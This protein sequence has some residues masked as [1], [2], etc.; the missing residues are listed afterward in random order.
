MNANHPFNIGLGNEQIEF[1]V[2]TDAGCMGTNFRSAAREIFFL[3]EF[4][5]STIEALQYG[6][7]GGAKSL[8]LDN[9]GSIEVGKI[10]DIVFFDSDPLNDVTVLTQPRIVIAKGYQL[11]ERERNYESDLPKHS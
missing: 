9:V 11:A 5:A 8:R 2:G 6:T 3:N 10:A 4:G 1:A 7:I